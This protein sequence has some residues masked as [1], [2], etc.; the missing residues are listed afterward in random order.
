MRKTPQGVLDEFIRILR[1]T[2]N[3]TISAKACGIVT[4]TASYHRESN[5]EFAK[6]WEYAMQEAGDKLEHE[7]VRRATQGVERAMMYQG[8]QVGVIREYSDRM[9]ELLLTG[10]KPEKYAH[11]WKGELSGRDGKALI[12]EVNIIETARRLAFI[13][14]QGATAQKQIVPPIELLAEEDKKDPVH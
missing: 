11:R 3:V 5:P 1:E 14:T 12:P 10:V 7:A 6:A 4:R 13:L 8:R 9:L 2:G